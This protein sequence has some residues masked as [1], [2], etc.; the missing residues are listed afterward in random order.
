MPS[1]ACSCPLVRLVG[2]GSVLL[3]PGPD[4]LGRGVFKAAPR[5][6]GAGQTIRGSGTITYGQSL[7]TILWDV[8]TKNLLLTTDIA[9]P[10]SQYLNE[11]I[12]GATSDGKLRLEDIRL[13]PVFGHNSIAGRV[14]TPHHI[15]E[16]HLHRWRL[17]GIVHR[18]VSTSV[19]QTPGATVWRFRPM[20]S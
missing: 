17:D 13:V 10:T 8:P 1:S 4:P 5:G 7:G 6:I 19:P 14:P 12:I 18:R 20:S 2:T 9:Q 15:F 3:E 11:G 16:L